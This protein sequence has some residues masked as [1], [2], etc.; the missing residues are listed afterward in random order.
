MAYHLEN[1]SWIFIF[2]KPKHSSVSERLV[3]GAMTDGEVSV[4]E[5]TAA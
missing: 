4:L 1:I 3:V 5:M 2:R